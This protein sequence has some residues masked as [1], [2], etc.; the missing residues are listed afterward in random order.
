[1]LSR[2]YEKIVR[3]FLQILYY[4]IV[5]AAGHSCFL[6]SRQ[7][8]RANILTSA[9]DFFVF[10]QPIKKI[11]LNLKILCPHS[12]SI[13]VPRPRRLRDEKRAMGTRFSINLNTGQI[14][15]LCCL[16][17]LTRSRPCL[18]HAMTRYKSRRRRY[19]R[20][21]WDIPDIFQA[22]YGG[23]ANFKKIVRV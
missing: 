19:E 15:R 14:Q 9:Q 11:D 6:L 8:I 3:I 21:L 16:P 22:N 12:P 7:Q 1:M 17:F 10:K 13:L 23:K 20:L 4:C 5:N 18:S 2:E